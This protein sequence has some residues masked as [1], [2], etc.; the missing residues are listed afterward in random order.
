M[1]PLIAVTLTLIVLC[2]AVISILAVFEVITTEVAV[3]YGIKSSAA[4]FILGLAFAIISLLSK[5]KNDSDQG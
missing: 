1:K 4:I 2:V 5:N 3:D